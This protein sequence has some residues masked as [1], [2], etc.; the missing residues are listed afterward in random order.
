MYKRFKHHI[1]THDEMMRYFGY[2]LLQYQLRLF[3]IIVSLGTRKVVS[4]CHLHQLL[5]RDS[6]EAIGAFLHVVTEEEEAS[7]SSHKL[8]KILPL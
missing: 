5:S 7:M 6:F 4:M 2:L 3:E 1:L 8:K